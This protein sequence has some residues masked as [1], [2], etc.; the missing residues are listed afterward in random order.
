MAQSTQSHV[1]PVEPAGEANPDHEAWLAAA[2]ARKF[3][4]HDNQVE[5]EV[6]GMLAVLRALAGFANVEPAARPYLFQSW[7]EYARNRVGQ[8]YDGESLQS[9]IDKLYAGNGP[10]A[11]NNDAHEAAYFVAVA[12]AVD[13][14][15]GEL[16][17]D[18]TKVEKDARKLVVEQ[19]AE[20]HRS[21]IFANAVKSAQESGRAIV[22]AKDR[23]RAKVAPKTDAAIDIAL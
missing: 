20:K 10:S 14:K 23:K 1:R 21:R 9:A 12:N 8:N 18:A 16:G 15:L 11:K 4:I 13:G 7:A 3:G 6:N 19:T 22:P 2:A 17:K 5:I